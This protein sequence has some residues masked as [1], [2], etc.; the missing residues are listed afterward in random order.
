MLNSISPSLWEEDSHWE[1]NWWGTCAGG[2]D[3]GEQEKQHLYL[4][5]MGFTFFHD[6]RSPYNIDMRGQSVLDVGG[7]PVSFLLGCVN[8]KGTVL[9][10]CDYPEWVSM[11]YKYC[12]IEYVKQ[13]AEDMDF[14]DKVFDILTIYNVLQHTEDPRLIIEKSLGL[15][16]QLRIFEWVNMGIRKGHHQSFTKP[17][18]DE[19]LGG[20]GKVETFHGEAQCFGDG[21]FGIFMGKHYGK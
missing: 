13:K 14:G 12:G 21:Y 16:K 5:K 4:R 15:C 19:W 10:P 9:D 8:V 20:Y 2:V 11:R 17:M 7:G 6:T 1:G 18:L 3:F